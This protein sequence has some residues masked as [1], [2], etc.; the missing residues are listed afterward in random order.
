MIPSPPTSHCIQPLPAV[1]SG[2]LVLSP[3][4]FPPEAGWNSP[5]AAELVAVEATEPLGLLAI[6]EA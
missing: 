3:F 2:V 6:E 4:P 5:S 1:D